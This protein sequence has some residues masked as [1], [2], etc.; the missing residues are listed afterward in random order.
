MK[1]DAT[2]TK[3]DLLTRLEALTRS[4]NPQATLANYT[5]LAINCD[6]F[7]IQYDASSLTFEDSDKP[8]IERVQPPVPFLIAFSGSGGKKALV[9]VQIADQNYKSTH[10][11]EYLEKDDAPP[12]QPVIGH[13]NS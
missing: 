1:T 12:L 8:L 11:D 9:R 3:N 4:L 6:A 5:S 2:H 13:D 10:D 7:P